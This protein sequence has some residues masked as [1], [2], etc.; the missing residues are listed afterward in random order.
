LIFG[1]PIKV[2]SVKKILN[3]ERGKG[4]ILLVKSKKPKTVALFSQWICAK[5]R[6]KE[7]NNHQTR[8]AFGPERKINGI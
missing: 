6:K 2:R 4:P 5:S 7:E 1:D 8:F 3:L